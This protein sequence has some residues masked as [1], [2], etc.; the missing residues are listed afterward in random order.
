VSTARDVTVRVTV[1]VPGR[2]SPT[3]ALLACAAATSRAELHT[4]RLALITSGAGVLTDLDTT[5]LLAGDGTAGR[6][7]LGGSS[8]LVDSCA[9][10]SHRIQD[11]LHRAL[12]AGG[13]D[14]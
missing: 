10:R 12:A 3:D 1:S 8:R 13:E 9:A 5:G 11:R 2:L 6:A 14:L 4:A 7:L